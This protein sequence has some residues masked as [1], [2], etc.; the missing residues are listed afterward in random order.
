[1]NLKEAFQAQN[2]I[3]HLLS[4]IC[5]FL[6]DE[7]NVTEVKERHLRSKVRSE[8]QDEEIEIPETRLY[9]FAPNTMIAIWQKLMVEKEKLGH[10]ISET[11]RSLDFDFD[12]A[13]DENKCRRE[14]CSNLRKLASLKGK[15]D[16]LRGQGTGYV[17]NKDGNQTEYHYDV[18]RIVTIDYDRN[19]VLSLMK[20][21]QQEAN[22][23]SQ[24]IDLALITA[25]VDYEP[26]FD[27]DSDSGLIFEELAK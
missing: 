22:A 26:I 12:A 8:E 2:T 10:A 11:K 7:D 13:V 14:F 21:L 20:K 3:N 18:E 24:K 1:M 5:D 17:F 25:T 23:V 9:D 15:S 16:R 4:R 19:K 27:I 6:E